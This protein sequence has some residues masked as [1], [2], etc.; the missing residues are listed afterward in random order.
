MC[1]RSDVKRPSREVR[2]ERSD[3][4]RPSWE[5]RRPDESAEKALS[6][7]PT[8][9]TL[10]QKRGR[11]KAYPNNLKKGKGFSGSG[12]KAHSE[13]K[14]SEPRELKR[15]GTKKRLSP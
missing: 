6:V 8:T 7:S 13:A 15:N 9:E 14:P 3:V 12:R 10:T 5:V 1:V 2:R 4:K 11:K